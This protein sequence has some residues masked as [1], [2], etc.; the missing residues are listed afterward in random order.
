VTL[1]ESGLASRGAGGPGAQAGAQA[2]RQTTSPD[3][4]GAPAYGLQ[5]LAAKLTE[6]LAMQASRVTAASLAWA[7]ND[8]EATRREGLAIAAHAKV[9][10]LLYA[11]HSGA[12]G[13]QGWA[14]DPDAKVLQ[15]A[16]NLKNVTVLTSSEENELSEELLEWRHGALAE[17]FLDALKGAADPKGIIRDYPL[18]DA[19]DKEVRSLTKGRQHLGTHPN[20]NGDLFMASH[21]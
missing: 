15:D 10:L 19:M 8:E 1:K 7:A 14:T 4:L 2:D 9:L 5:A 6:A 17:V 3:A 13:A 12:V 20:F 21:Y 16:M 11:C 18:I